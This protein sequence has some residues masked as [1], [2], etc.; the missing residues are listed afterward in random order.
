M[1]CT[2]ATTAVITVLNVVAVM[3]PVGVTLHAP[4][5]AMTNE[6][7]AHV[8]AE[9]AGIRRVMHVNEIKKHVLVTELQIVVQ[10]ELL[11]AFLC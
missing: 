3:T 7:V 4:A 8:N 11:C 6:H 10:M 9:K 5:V 2:G 1:N